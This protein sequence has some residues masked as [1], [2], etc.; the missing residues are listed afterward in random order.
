MSRHPDED[1]VALVRDGKRVVVDARDEVW[2]S[3][4]VSEGWSVTEDSVPVGPGSIFGHATSV[5]SRQKGRS[6]T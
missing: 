3:R 6:A 2:F 1:L 5:A 4:L